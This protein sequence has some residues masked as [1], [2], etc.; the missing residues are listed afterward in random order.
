MNSLGMKDKVK[1]TGNA[2]EVEVGKAIDRIR[3]GDLPKKLLAE[4]LS[5]RHP[6]Y[7]ERPSYQM[8]RIRGYVMASFKEAGLSDSSFNFLLEEL[9]N[10]RTA[11][12][13]AAAARGLRGAKRPSSQ[14][15]G[16]LF[17]ALQNMRYHDDSLDLSVFKPTWPL[18]NPSSARKE[19]FLTFQWLKGYAKGA[20][21][22]LKA[23]L[24]NNVDFDSQMRVVI[25][26]TIEVIEKD[27]RKLDLSCC[28]VDGK[29]ERNFS[30]VLKE[31]R[32]VKSI[33]H[34]EVQNQDGTSKHLGEFTGHKSA[35][36]AFFYTRCMNPNKCTLTINKM[37]W[38]QKKL[39]NLGLQ[40]E[41]NLLAFTYDPAYDTS[42]KMQ[43]FGENRG[44]DFG[45]NMNMLRTKP[46]DFLILSDFFELGVNHVS[47][48]VNQH[49]LEL[50]LLNKNGSVQTSYTRIQWEVDKVLNDIRKSLKKSPRFG[51]FSSPLNSIQQVAFPLVLAFFPKCP[52]C[53]A[54]YLSAFGVSSLQSIP[55]SPQLIPWIMLAMVVNLFVLYRK[56]R[57]R[58]GLIPFW[59]S[60]IGGILVLGPG[61]WIPNQLFAITGV[62]F[63]LSGALL[64]SLPFHMWM[65]FIHVFSSLFRKLKEKMSSKIDDEGYKNI[66]MKVKDFI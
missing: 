50:Y 13:V 3:K 35:V 38:L 34:L 66:E 11:Y 55:Y 37:G 19:V 16:Y 25:Q 57:V 56:A 29:E 53:W 42:P 39:A 44:V 23:L 31:I 47:S 36:V 58:N 12:M 18:K 45:S 40:D 22:E 27:S 5:E 46:E 54:V 4:L 62:I 64:N 32:N 20:L 48:T 21:P 30:S 52:I 49:R 33:G 17:Q 41:V 24:R 43:L 9:Q 63:I 28:E 61:Y 26:E 2:S 60:L 6:V 8:N 10:G 65:K 15:V 1:L 59:I 51:W 7:E 14:F